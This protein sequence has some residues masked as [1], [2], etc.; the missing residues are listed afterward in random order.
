MHG[1]GHELGGRALCHQRTRPRRRGSAESDRRAPHIEG[2]GAV[3][4]TLTCERGSWTGEPAP[5][6]EYQWYRDG[7]PIAGATEQK[8]TVEPADQEH[9]LSCRVTATNNEGSEEAESKTASAI[10]THV[11][12]TDVEG[13]KT[14]F[15]PPAPAPPNAR[16]I[17]ASLERQLTTGAQQGAPEGG[18]QGRGFAFP[19]IP[20]WEGTLEV[21]WYQ[22]EKVKTAHGVKRKR[23]VLARSQNS[24]ASTAESSFKLKLTPYGQRAL[25]HSK[26]MKLT[27]EV[28]F[29]IAHDTPATWYATFVL[30]SAEPEVR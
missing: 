20:P 28:A 8:Y 27:M 4:R 1:D 29:T 16:E 19:F 5:S 9:T 23:L 11:A 21:S 7:A 15:H 2:T 10:V 26:H 13:S 18:P 22:V 25:A 6:F 24:Y 14:A 3:G 12:Q 17:L 30:G